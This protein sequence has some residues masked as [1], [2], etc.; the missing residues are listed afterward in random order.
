MAS[1]VQ[2]FIYLGNLNDGPKDGDDKANK[3]TASPFQSQSRYSAD[4]KGAEM[5]MKQSLVFDILHNC[6]SAKQNAV[7]SE[8]KAT[9]TNRALLYLFLDILMCS[10]LTRS[11][12]FLRFGPRD[13][14]KN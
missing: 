4:L 9:S 11:V 1:C 2:N 13:L 14:L 12:D 8:Y 10:L 7:A 5:Y 6:H 3:P